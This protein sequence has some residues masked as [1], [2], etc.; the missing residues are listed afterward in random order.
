MTGPFEQPSAARVRDHPRVTA[1]LVLG[2][3]SLVGAVV[4]LPAA[5]G[6][7]ACY[8]GASA[9]RTI[10]REPER[11]SGHGQATAGLVLGA[12]ASAILALL[13]VVSVLAAVLL[14]VAME[15]DTGY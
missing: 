8:L 9:R 12:I 4:V 7:V 2:L 1:A 14:A 3:V 15:L 5:L 11:W 13:A 10:E 6:P